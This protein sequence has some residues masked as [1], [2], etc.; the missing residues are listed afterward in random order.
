M[1]LVNYL[2]SMKTM[3]IIK[4]NSQDS[5]LKKMFYGVH[6]LT[7]SYY[8]VWNLSINLKNISLSI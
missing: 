3:E 8:F 4:E 2:I 1:Y 6:P 7:F 5:G